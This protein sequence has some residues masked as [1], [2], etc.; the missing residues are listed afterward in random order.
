LLIVEVDINEGAVH[1]T[2]HVGTTLLGGGRAIIGY[3]P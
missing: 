1:F 2:L 3:S